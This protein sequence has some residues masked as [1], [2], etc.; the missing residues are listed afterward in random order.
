MLWLVILFVIFLILLSFLFTNFLRFQRLKRLIFSEEQTFEDDLEKA[1]MQLLSERQT[2]KVR[3]SYFKQVLEKLP[4]GV[5]VFNKDYKI[6][7]TN[8][9]A[10]RFLM[11]S[12]KGQREKN[13]SSPIEHSF[14]LSN[15]VKQFIETGKDSFDVHDSV[16]KN[17]YRVTVHQISSDSEEEIIPIAI[18]EDISEERRLEEFKRYLVSDLSHQLKTP[19][20]S[21]KIAVEALQDYGLLE[22]KEKSLR[23][24]KNLKQDVERLGEI[25]E[26]ILL[27]S[28]IQSYTRNELKIENFSL[29]D[30][31]KEIVQLLE[32]QAQK[33]Q[34][35]FE[36]Q[37]NDVVVEADKGLIEE[38]ILNIV[39]NAVKFSEAGKTIYVRVGKEE[40]RAFVSV[41]NF[42]PVIEKEEIPLLF[43][44]F[45][46]S[47]KS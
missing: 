17:S 21:M 3:L 32:P 26:K 22:D 39:E 1:V 43:Q 45:Y 40:K 9:F 18:I 47:R 31:V 16:T 33:K 10:N 35:N 20:A 2:I 15:M 29:S 41:T 25:L 14:E 19:I 28:K 37:T 30:L 5:V 36:M 38:A 8:R 34:L 27:L 23:L 24:L 4:V 42:G 12:I 7:Y 11:R 44:R 6:V 46:R 13:I